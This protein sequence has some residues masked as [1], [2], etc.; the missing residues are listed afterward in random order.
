MSHEIRTP[1]NGIIGMTELALDTDATPEQREYL[2]MVKSSAE[3]LLA[4]INDIL[5]FSKIEAGKL[6]LDPVA[7]ELRD[8]LADMVKALALRA[9]QKG[10][11]LAFHVPPEVP[12]HLVGDPGRL[13][14]VIVNL[15]GNAIK[16]TAEGEVVARVSLE[17][18]GG[19]AARLHFTVSDTGIGIP[20]EKRGAIFD[21]FSQADGTTTRRYGGTGLGLSISSR[22][23]ELM[24]GSIWVE[25]RVGRGSTFH[26]T[27]GFGLR[28][29]PPAQAAPPERVSV[30]DLP[31]LIVDD[32][33]TNRLILEEVLSSWRMRPA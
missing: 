15:L 22:L 12:D 19:D 32:N 31:V 8:S 7:F 1:M 6:D 10:L 16:F 11:E 30:E 21:A 3:S 18:L 29:A 25:S 2:Q 27:A 20:E 23:V 28:A 14:Q 5:D 33:A 13:R 4:L 9:H 26:F 17:S 24:G